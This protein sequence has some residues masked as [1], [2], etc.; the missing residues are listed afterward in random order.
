[1]LDILKLKYFICILIYI[2]EKFILK[3]IKY[4]DIFQKLFYV[5]KYDGIHSVYILYLIFDIKIY[6]IKYFSTRIIK[7]YYNKNKIS[8][9]CIKNEINNN[10]VILSIVYLDKY[11]FIN[12]LEVYNCGIVY[13]YTKFFTHVYN[14]IGE[15]RVEYNMLENF[16]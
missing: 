6:T 7:I 15:R 16:I 3:Y 10:K 8:D 12:I 14:Y 2:L 9:V 4:K 13:H 11:R 5:E 1:M